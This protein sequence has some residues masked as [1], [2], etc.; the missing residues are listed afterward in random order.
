MKIHKLM[1]NQI[2]AQDV[3]SGKYP[4]YVNS[5]NSKPC[6][7][8]YRGKKAMYAIQDTTSPINTLILHSPHKSTYLFLSCDARE[9]AEYITNHEMNFA[10]T[11]ANDARRAEYIETNEWTKND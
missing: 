8:L 2:V 6:W 4:S 9:I 3:M 10:K 11:I 1:F 5:K 7:S